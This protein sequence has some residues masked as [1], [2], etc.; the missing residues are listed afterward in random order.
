MTVTIHIEADTATEAK[1]EMARLLGSAVTMPAD[2][3]VVPADEAPAPQPD[4]AE[5]EK[6]TPAEKPSAASGGRKHS[7]SDGDRKRRTKEQLAT[8]KEI[9]ELAAALG[10]AIDTTVPA[11]R[12]VVQLR[13]ASAG[14]AKEETKAN[15]STA[16]ED[17]KEPEAAGGEVSKATLEDVRAA[18]GTVVEAHDMPTA[19]AWLEEVG[20]CKKMSELPEDKYG[21]V[22]AEAAKKAAEPAG[23]MG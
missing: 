18:L 3:I 21:H 14:A 2:P 12:L 22:I 9:E 6:E 17:R 10:I 13:E 15:I 7:E 1:Q 20:G 16:P 19:I 4:T 5:P 11:D 8:D 23:V